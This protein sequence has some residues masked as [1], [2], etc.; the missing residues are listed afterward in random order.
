MRRAYFREKNLLLLKAIF[1]ITGTYN[2]S[3]YIREIR[4]RVNSVIFYHNAHSRRIVRI[5]ADA[6]IDRR[7]NDRTRR[8]EYGPPFSLLLAFFLSLLLIR[9]DETSDEAAIWNFYDAV[10]VLA[11]L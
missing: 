5:S 10:T 9:N 2:L 3:L 1:L 6:G 8:Y 4:T 11:Y 7:S